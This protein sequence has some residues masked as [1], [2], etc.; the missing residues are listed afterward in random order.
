MSGPKPKP[1]T[2]GELPEAPDTLTYRQREL[3]DSIVPTLAASVVLKPCDSTGLADMILCLDRLQ[4]AEA[5]IDARGMLVEGHRGV[6][7]KNPSAM[8]ARMYRESFMTWA[9]AYG[10]DIKSRRTLPKP[11]GV[12]PLQSARDALRAMPN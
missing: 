2:A 4:Q 8:V 1:A 11:Q 5:D 7:T 9:K 12:S 3:W 6:P 10:M